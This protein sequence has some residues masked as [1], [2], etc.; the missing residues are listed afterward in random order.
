[1]NAGLVRVPFRHKVESAAA[2]IP[3]VAN[4][5]EVSALRISGLDIDKA[6]DLNT[7]FAAAFELIR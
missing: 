7:R 5:F 6:I 1:L 3:H 4:F 2:K